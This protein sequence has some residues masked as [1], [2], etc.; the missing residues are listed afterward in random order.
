MEEGRAIQA[1]KQ[2][3]LGGLETLVN[4]YYLPAVRA[5]YLVVQDHDLA[6]DMVQTGFA[7]LPKTIQQ[8]DERRSFKPWFF[9]SV[10]NRAISAVRRE[11]RVVDFPVDDTGKLPQIPEPSATPEEEVLQ[12]ERNTAVWQVLQ[13]LK[14]IQRTAIVLRYFLEFSENEIAETLKKPKSTVKWTLY[15]ARKNLQPLLSSLL[16]ET[17]NMEGVERK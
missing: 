6:E 15:A 13:Q 16:D 2:G 11:K 14:P 4:Q 5:V 8:F 10:I 17:E 7:G 1:L 3:D 12:A 9:R